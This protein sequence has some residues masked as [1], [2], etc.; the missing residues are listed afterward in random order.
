MKRLSRILWVGGVYLCIGPIGVLAQG[1]A[2]V[3]NLPATNPDE[4]YID[5][6]DGTVTDI[7]TGL[8]WRQ[9]SEGLSGAGCTIGSAEIH[10]WADALVEAASSEFAGYS[11]WRVP[12]VR[13][14]L[15]LME[16]CRS[17]PAINIRFFP[18]TPGADAPPV[19]GS[20]FWTSSLST[21]AGQA[22][23]QNFSY[24]VNFVY[25]NSADAERGSRFYV[26]LVRGGQ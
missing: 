1:A 12:N 22:G 25:G 26:R 17:E 21:G 5:H 6:G 15:S 13:E 9:C 4:V 14:L 11:D 2:C 7:R 23:A 18:N 16:E 10:T 19:F 20:A 24:A 8:M 3:N